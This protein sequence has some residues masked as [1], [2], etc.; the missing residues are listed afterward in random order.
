MTNPPK[1][2]LLLQGKLSQ[3]ASLPTY[4]RLVADGHQSHF[5]E[6]LT[7]AASAQLGT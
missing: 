7:S 5:V 2:F 3:P 4:T 6:F 1:T